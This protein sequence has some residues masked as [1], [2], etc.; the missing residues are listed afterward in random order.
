MIRHLFKLMWKR[1][2]SN[3]LLTVEIAASALV[4]FAVYSLAIANLKTFMAPMGFNDKDVWLVEFER[5]PGIQLDSGYVGNAQLQ[6]TNTPGVKK[7]ALTA[8]NAPFMVSHMIQTTAAHAGRTREVFLYQ[9]DPHFAEVLEMPL[10]EGRWFGKQDEVGHLLPIVINE[11]LKNELF[12]PATANGQT[13]EIDKQ[14]YRVVGVVGPY[15]VDH[16]FQ[17]PRAAA[18]VPIPASSKNDV[19]VIVRVDDA[20]G[21]T[22]ARLMANLAPLQPGVKPSCEA[23]TEKRLT[24][25]QLN[26]TPIF[27]AVGICLFLIINVVLGLVGVFWQS[28]T[29]RRTEIALRRSVGATARDVVR[30][31]VGEAW[32][33]TTFAVSLILG[34][35]VLFPIMGLL[36]TAPS[37]YWL[38]IGGMLVTL[39]G[40]VTLSVLYPSRLA[41]A[42]QPTEALRAE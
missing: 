18:F 41:S 21:Q 9:T 37:T 35:V 7:F 10:E 30:Q 31:L 6:I 8:T 38:A 26:I 3:F 13:I 36:G 23:L 17:S 12:G 27:I 32:L 29:R 22:E 16:E 42:I 15:K 20:D 19:R 33:I 25:R 11:V 14:L 24:Q 40:L 39:Y 34:A 28:I 5:E 1:R 4:L 2:G